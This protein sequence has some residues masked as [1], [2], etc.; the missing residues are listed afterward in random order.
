M[1]G[2]KRAN[3]FCTAMTQRNKTCA[4]C[5]QLQQRVEERATLEAKTLQ[6]YAGLTE[7]AVPVRVGGRVLGYLQTGQVFVRA[8]SKNQFKDLVRAG[9]GV[10]AGAGTPALESAYFKTRL[11]TPV[12]YGGII[13]L[14]AVF[15]GQLAAASNQMLLTEATADSLVVMKGRAFI[16]DHQGEALCLG[17]VARAVNMSSWNFCKV[18][19]KATGLG[20]TEF[21]A[22]AR[23]ESVKQML[24]NVHTR[25]SEAGFAAGFQSLSQFN[26][27]FR[28]VTGEA[29][30]GYRGRIHGWH[31]G[32]ARHHAPPAP[33]D[34][35]E[36]PAPDRSRRP[37]SARD[38]AEFSREA[39]LRKVI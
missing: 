33:G 10:E 38:L 20:F 2:S 18:F 34:V 1:Q 19:K 28:R 6:C 36:P 35:M 17:D 23:V 9:L 32:A 24:L 31:R 37:G 14:L 13:R 30:G 22:R 16:I 12:Q 25:V 3:P 27:V 15:A 4:A 29:P 39:P 21:L 5:L 26:R 8:P 7:T 11:I